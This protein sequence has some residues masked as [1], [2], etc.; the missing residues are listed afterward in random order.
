MKSK[1]HKSDHE[2][3]DTH[4]W[5]ISYADFVTL[6]FAFF[7]VMYSISSVNVSKYKSLSEGMKSAFNKKDQNKATQSTADLSDGPETKNTKGQF[8]DGMEFLKKSL[9]GL[10]DANYQINKQEGWIE[11]NIQ[12]G[13]LFESGTS[14][15]KTEALLKLMSVA[16]KI[17]NLPYTIVV[18]GY[19]DNIPIDTP[20]Y[21]SNWELSASRA[22]TVGRALNGFGVP[23][24]HILVTGYGEQ[25]PIGDNST[26]E[27]RSQ[28]RRVTLIIVKDRSVSRLFNPQID[29]THSSF[30]DMGSKVESTKEP[31]K[32]DSINKEAQ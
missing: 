28:N 3:I 5:V 15:L 29:Q 22:A 9:S 4:R 14:D 24:E 20:Q 8:T 11:I 23:S 1:R 16:A 17:K 10:E 6:L 21:P 7:V 25:Y 26:E 32:D 30:I 12:A 13:S 31:K 18:E 27:G 2:K 19:T